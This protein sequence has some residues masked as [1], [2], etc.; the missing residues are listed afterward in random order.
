MSEPTAPK[1]FSFGKTGAPPAQPVEEV[2]SVAP[3][4]ENNGVPAPAGDSAP[5]N[6]PATQSHNP[7]AF[8]T[9]EEDE[10]SDP[11]DQRLPRLN[12]V[13]KSSQEEWLK[14]GPV[15]SLLLKGQV[16][17]PLPAKFVVAGARPKIWIEKTKF[18][19]STKAR[20]A[21]SIDDV[22][23]LGGTDRWAFSKEN[24]KITSTKPWFM[25]SVTLLF[26]IEKPDA[27]PEDHFAYEADGKLYAAALLSVKST[28]FEAVWVAINTERHG[29]LSEGFNSRYV[30]FNTYIKEFGGNKVGIPKISF[31]E[32]TTDG[33]RAL[34][35]KLATGE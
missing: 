34:A 9:G 31:G 25:P 29:V 26:L 1:K 16:S 7:P 12:I 19:S 18:G 11:A 15:G 3:A 35:K 10:P 14:L 2:K 23:K 33:V 24:D 27:L 32:K 6:L 20:I 22:V 8:Y 21:R 13:Q 17:L 4:P 28:S 5:S 30:L